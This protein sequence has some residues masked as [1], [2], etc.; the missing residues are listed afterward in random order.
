MKNTIKS[1]S[2][3][4][5]IGEHKLWL[6][7]LA[8]ILVILILTLAWNTSGLNALLARYT[9]QYVSD[10]TYQLTS[11]IASRFGALERSLKHLADSLPSLSTPSSTERFLAEKAQ[12]S[13][14]ET[15]LVL[16]PS[17]RVMPQDFDLSTLQNLFGIQASFQGE[18]A[19]LYMDGQDL[20]FSVP[21]YQSDKVSGVLVGIRKKENIQS[22]IQPK[23][24]DGQ[25]LSCIIDHQGS[26]VISP[27][28]LKP[29]LHLDSVFSSGEDAQITQ[30][31][32]QM[33]TD[34][35]QQR[36]G[37]LSF[38][39][40]DGS[41]L[42]MS[43]RPLLV[44]D[45]FLLTLVPS[46]LISGEADAYMWR[47]F[48]IVGSIIVVFLLF[49]MLVFRFYRQNRAQL[50]QF[51]FFDPLTGGMNN[52][53]FLLSCQN[54]VSAAPPNT[55]TVVFLNLKGFKLI[56]ETFGPDVGTFVLK[57]CYRI[58]SRHVEE[59]ELL[60][61][62]HADQFFLC[63]KESA[64]EKIQA[65]LDAISEDIRVSSPNT[66]IEHYIVLAQGAY[67]I[68]QPDLDLT[69]VQDRARTAC[70]R[71]TN[72]AKCMFYTAELTQ[73]MQREQSFNILFENSLQD[74]HFQV[75]LQPKV[76]LVD[77]R[78][79]G[80]EA[81]VRW[82]HPDE[83]LISPAEFIPALEA[84]GKICRL[85]CY[86]FESICALLRRWIDAGSSPLPI[87]VNLSR[88]HFL[89]P[90]FLQEFSQLKKQYAIPD[91]LIEF[92]L[93]ESIFFGDQQIDLVKHSIS[94]MHQCGF[95]CSLDD[96]GVGFSSLALLK[97]FQVD[98]IKLDRRFF[99][100]LST[101]KAQNVVASFIALAG[102]LGIS[103]VAEGIETEEQL[104]FLKQMNCDMV[105]GYIYSKPLPIPEFEQRITQEMERLS[106]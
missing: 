106:P 60:S 81:L 44:N 10:V 63:L 30:A 5:W 16:D 57:Y 42:L 54:L 20:L 77:G 9:A 96:F 29:F 55:Y 70:Y 97:E 88:V 92:E 91:G 86:V 103:V 13:G 58:F 37:M 24:F 15:L 65:R 80:A 102:K 4:P 35:L 21:I 93:T 45:W 67:Q 49:L 99:E 40:A 22:L 56:N 47:T 19:V 39:A 52:P 74:R 46:D 104:G 50:I 101:P 59:G 1:S 6:G 26:V 17:G 31:I 43:Y 76:R 66:D 84:S 34:M 100:G 89:H 38:T 33:R 78:T 85:D 12:A 51:A 53:A 79:C 61:R 75:Y 14:F 28:D 72:P 18:S 2:S 83:G 36:S 25:G 62:S 95:L 11:D 82:F 87:S 98:S 32:E 73:Q 90:G 3:K 8:A 68:D 71:Q 69:I 94:E 41:A 27:T 64:P 48:I 23:S 105:Q 7:C